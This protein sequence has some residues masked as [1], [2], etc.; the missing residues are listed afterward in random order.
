MSDQS[1]EDYPRRIEALLRV[2]AGDPRPCKACA[3]P[4][5]FV[6]TRAGKAAPYSSTGL[7]HFA[8]CPGAGRFRRER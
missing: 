7:S 2:V 3:T 1:A 5:W 8:D 6:T 4:I